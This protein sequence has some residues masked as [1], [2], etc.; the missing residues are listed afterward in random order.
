MINKYGGV[1]ALV[2]AIVALIVALG[3]TGIVGPTGP[4]GGAAGPSHTEIQ[5]FRAG[6]VEGGIVRATSTDD[7]TATFLAIDLIQ[8]A[9]LVSI[10]NFS[11]S[12]NAITVTFPATSTIPHY[13]PNPGDKHS[14]SLCNATTTTGAFADF[15]FALGTGMNLQQSTST[16]NLFSGQCADLTFTRNTDS[17]FEVDYY[18]GW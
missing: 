1:G 8:R 5:E 14:I 10:L 11:P 9:G 4:T 7:T 3:A 12:L 18:L 6:S 2:V 15:T 16:L 13:L 17:D